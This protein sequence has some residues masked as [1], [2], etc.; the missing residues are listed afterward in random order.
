[1]EK[2]TAC[3][4]ARVRILEQAFAQL[5]KKSNSTTRTP[6]LSRIPDDVARLI[7]LFAVGTHM[8]SYRLVRAHMS[9]LAPLVQ[10]LH[11]MFST[12]LGVES[13]PWLLLKEHRNWMV[14]ALKPPNCLLTTT[15]KLIDR[16]L[17]P[18]QGMDILRLDQHASIDKY[19]CLARV[20]CPITL[21]K[22]NAHLLDQSLSRSML[23]RLMRHRKHALHVARHCWLYPS[24]ELLLQV[25][26]SYS[27]VA[28]CYLALRTNKSCCDHI[29][30]GLRAISSEGSAM[31]KLPIPSL[32]VVTASVCGLVCAVR[33]ERK[34][35]RY[36]P[37]PCIEQRSQSI[38]SYVTSITMIAIGAAAYGFG[39]IVY[40]RKR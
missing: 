8:D 3:H 27:L 11:P 30:Q 21:H 33:H 14:L 7:A 28:A 16:I 6:D 18:S 22:S 12:Y 40:F 37:R 35:K 4:Q 39:S 2:L 5:D 9:T 38:L 26:L 25:G 13:V 31:N 15:L 24:F 32:A 10:D 17:V 1:M 36:L 20:I 19:T 34:H 29:S 23:R